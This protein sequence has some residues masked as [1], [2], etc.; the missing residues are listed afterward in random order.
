MYFIHLKIY[1]T[2]KILTETSTSLQSK[3]SQI[4]TEHTLQSLQNSHA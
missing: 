3:A 2:L 1:P 4:I